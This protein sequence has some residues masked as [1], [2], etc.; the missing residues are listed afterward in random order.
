MEGNE[1]YLATAKWRVVEVEYS[2][3]EIRYDIEAH[4]PLIGWEKIGSS[5]DNK[6]HALDIVHRLNATQPRKE[7]RRTVLG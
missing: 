6:E 1:R 2:N 3:N 4:T 5:E 7:V